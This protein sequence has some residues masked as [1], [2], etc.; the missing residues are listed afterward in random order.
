MTFSLPALPLSASLSQERNIPY[1][2]RRLWTGTK[3]T[4]PYCVERSSLISYEK[5]FDRVRDS[6]WFLVFSLET[7]SHCSLV[8]PVHLLFINQHG[9]IVIF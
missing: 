5:G 6:T 3:N 9:R 4:K 2:C 8:S 1:I 7:G